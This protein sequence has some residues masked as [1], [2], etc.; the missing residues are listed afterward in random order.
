MWDLIRSG[1][2]FMPHRP[3]PRVAKACCPRYPD[4]ALAISARLEPTLTFP[5]LS[6]YTGLFLSALL[7]ATLVPAASE[8]MLAGLLAAEKG[9]PW[10]LFS[11]ATAGNTLG[12]VINWL[13][14][15]AIE[16][17]RD[18][19]WF[20]VSAAQYESASRAFQ[21]YGTWSLLFAWLPIVGDPLTVVAGALR[22][23]F[24]R[25]LVLVAIGKAARYAVVAATVA[26]WVR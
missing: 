1:L 12:S 25:F 21:R 16:R 2:E 19:R 23:P 11:V 5:D 7:A 26:W 24:L 18:R 3:G 17:F 20:P 6:I 14:G 9:A 15:R 8:V 10:L 13:L 22:V 4:D